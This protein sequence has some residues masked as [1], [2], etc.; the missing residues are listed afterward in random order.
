MSSMIFPFSLYLSLQCFKIDYVK[1]VQSGWNV[2]MR[3]VY[4]KKLKGK[5]NWSPKIEVNFYAMSM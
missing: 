3:G 1:S 4:L 2:D 5:Q